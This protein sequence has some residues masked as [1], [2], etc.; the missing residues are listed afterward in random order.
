[1]EAILEAF[2]KAIKRLVTPVAML[3]AAALLMK[4][5]GQNEA[6]A[7]VTYVMIILLCFG[8]LFYAVLSFMLTIEKLREADL[9]LFSKLVISA[10]FGPIY[11]VLGVAA[12][13][14]SFDKL[15]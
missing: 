12:L 2:D 11:V 3:I 8:A 15:G 5:A 7:N 6:Y 4:G 13:K 9:P 10:W 1:M 14:L